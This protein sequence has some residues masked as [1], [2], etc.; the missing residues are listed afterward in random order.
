[1]ALTIAATQEG[2]WPELIG[3]S[4]YLPS[5]V[6]QLTS[7]SWQS[8]MSDKTSG[9]FRSTKPLA[10]PLSQY[11]PVHCRSPFEPF[12]GMQILDMASGAVQIEPA[13]LAP[14]FETPV[15]IA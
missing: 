14:P 7:A 3:W 11:F 5:G 4:E 13:R 12:A 1:M 9:G 6:I 2:P 10:M 8:P 15:V